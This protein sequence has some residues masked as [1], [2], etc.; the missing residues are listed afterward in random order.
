MLSLH[1]EFLNYSEG[2]L[3]QY[4]LIYENT[5]NRH[6][7][8]FYGMKNVGC[9]MYKSFISYNLDYDCHKI[10]TRRACIWQ[11]INVIWLFYENVVKR[12]T[13][14]TYNL[15]IWFAKLIIVRSENLNIFISFMAQGQFEDFFI[16]QQSLIMSIKLF[17]NNCQAVYYHGIIV[18]VKFIWTLNRRLWGDWIL[19]WTS[20][21]TQV[22]FKRKME[23]NFVVIR[24]ENATLPRI[25]SSRKGT[26]FNRK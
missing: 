2:C 19:N 4:I 23:H 9:I 10:V 26:Y 8:I 21:V 17:S 14:I 11:I 7:N 25:I 1:I 13:V 24:Y 18:I 5:K 6:C 15:V 20:K 16:T 22:Q 12:S 3:L